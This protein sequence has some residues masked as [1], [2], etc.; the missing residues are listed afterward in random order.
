MSFADHLP[1]TGISETEEGIRAGATVGD[2]RPGVA[3]EKGD[4]PFHGGAKFWVVGSFGA[5]ESTVG[6]VKI[7]VSSRGHAAEK[8]GL[9]LCRVRSDGQDAVAGFRHGVTL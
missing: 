7:K 5:A 8:R 9:I 6:N 4:V 2:E 1:E 3:I